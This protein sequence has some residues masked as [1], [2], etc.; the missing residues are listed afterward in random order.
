MG[1]VKK[2]KK[3]TV[4]SVGKKDKFNKLKRVGNRD[5]TVAVSRNNLSKS[6]IKR[7]NQGRKEVTSKLMKKKEERDKRKA[8]IKKKRIIN[9]DD[10]APEHFDNDGYVLVSDKVGYNKRYLNIAF[11][12]YLL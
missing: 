11:E 3:S 2:N 9:Q 8:D 12:L 7:L 4:S 10:D 1:L 5:K 6:S